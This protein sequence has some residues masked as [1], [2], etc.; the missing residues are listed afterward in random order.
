M[1]WLLL[2]GLLWT[3]GSDVPIVRATLRIDA[4]LSV[5][6]WTS[7]RNDISAAERFVLRRGMPGNSPKDN[8]ASTGT[9]EWGLKNWADSAG[10]RLQ[11]WYSPNHANARSGWTEGIPIRVVATYGGSDHTL[12]T[13]RLRFAD[14]IP[15]RYGPQRVRCFATDAMDDLAN[16]EVRSVDPQVDASEVECLQAIIAAMPADSRPV[17]TSY[18]TALETFPY[19]L[20]NLSGGVMAMSA[21]VDVADSCQG[22]IYIAKDGTFTYINRHTWS[23]GVSDFTFDETMIE[24]EDGIVVPSDLSSVFND[25]S[26]TAHPKMGVAATVLCGIAGPQYVGPGETIELWL[27]YR[28]PDNPDRL[29]GGHTFTT[30][31]VEDTDYDARANADGSGLDLSTN[32]T[33]DVDPFAA[34]ALFT[35]TNTGATG[36]YLVNGAGTP[37]LQLRG[38][39]LYDNGPETRR[40]A[41]V[42]S[43]GTRRFEADLKYQGD[44]AFAAS[45]AQYIRARYE[46]LGN[47]IALITFNPQ[48]SDAL[49]TEALTVEIGTV[50]TASETM[51]GVT[52]VTAIVQ[53]IEME[54]MKGDMLAMRYVVAPAS[55]F[56]VWIAGIAGSSEA[57]TTT[58]PGF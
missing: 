39:A 30:P 9:C 3:G 58:I 46:S 28:D 27:D 12:W 5:G 53:A 40:S 14:P 57:G 17:A 49:M 52:A 6:F 45:V 38:T 43:Y 22:Y 44:G 4:Q 35:V 10:A 34:S 13:G 32:L 25:V 56:K 26:A 18:D 37:L 42:Q 2:A 50:K 23:V 1:T 8:T 54:V 11:G 41:S 48:K 36:A 24:R 31:L 55:P 29:I 19:A 47:Q 33:V 16:T 21:A 15:G 7:L 20:D 51:S